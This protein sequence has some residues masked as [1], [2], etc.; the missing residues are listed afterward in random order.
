MTKF[1]V[2]TEKQKEPKKKKASK[3]AD[4]GPGF[5]KKTYVPRDVVRTMFRERIHQRA[6]KFAEE[7]GKTPLAMAQVATNAIMEEL[8][9][10]EREQV[11]DMVDEWT[12]GE[13]MSPTAKI[14]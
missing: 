11:L 9:K 8:T 14:L 7:Q 6:Q 1:F 10:A 13:N 12:T 4:T 3:Q 2:S 5:F